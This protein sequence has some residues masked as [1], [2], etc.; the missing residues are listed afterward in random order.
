MKKGTVI[1]AQPG[2]FEVFVDDKN[3]R[4]FRGLEIVGWLVDLESEMVLPISIDGINDEATNFFGILTP[5]QQVVKPGAQT[6]ESWGQAEESL[7][8]Y[9][10][11]DLP[12]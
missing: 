1:P 6:F 9:D 11:S 12:F 10:R 4:L 5:A 8:D 7:A 3:K 2:Y